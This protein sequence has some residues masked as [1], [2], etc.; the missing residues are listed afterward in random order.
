[1]G[2]D[3]TLNAAQLKRTAAC[4]ALV[5]LVGCGDDDPADPLVVGT[6]TEV[7]NGAAPI[8]VTY[9]ADRTYKTSAG[10]S[11]TWGRA[12][13]TVLRGFGRDGEAFI[14]HLALSDD[15]QTMSLHDG[16]PSENVS[17]N[18]VATRKR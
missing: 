1:M 8:D 15:D 12:Q 2:S 17:L 3:A 4:L 5:V 18:I 16:S 7:R 9:S 14:F 6:W 11:G 13:S 10:E